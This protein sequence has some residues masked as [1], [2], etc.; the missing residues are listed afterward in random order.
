M[1]I[2]K[3][4]F[5]M[6]MKNTFIWATLFVAQIMGSMVYGKVLDVL[7]PDKNIK[8]SIELKD[9][10][11][12]SIFFHDDVLLN[13]C[14]LGMTLPKEVLG[15]NP[16]LE[17]AQEGTVD[18]TRRREIPLKNALV[19][20]HNNYLRMDMAGNYAVE[21]R[22]FDDGVAYRF[23]TDRKK[24]LEVIDEEF[25]INFSS[26]YRAYV[27]EAQAFSTSYE[28]VYTRLQTESY[29]ADAIMTYLPALLEHPDGYKILISEADLVDY[30]CMF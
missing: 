20:N 25:N 10:I 8:V 22:V 18:E 3:T 26:D 19:R 11:Y 1:V 29:G 7:S 2:K 13:N 27:G 9:K 5:N 14:T 24:R 15:A 30:P 16:V 28:S 4:F 6:K 12:Y 21:F 23:I 17:N